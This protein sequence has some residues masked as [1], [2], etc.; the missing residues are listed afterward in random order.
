MSEEEYHLSRRRNGQARR[1]RIREER[2][3]RMYMKPSLVNLYRRGVIEFDLDGDL[4]IAALGEDETNLLE[5][6]FVFVIKAKAGQFAMELMER[7]AVGGY[8]NK[9]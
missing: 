5:Q 6:G 1:P 4:L 8:G 3:S 9:V 2:R 7:D